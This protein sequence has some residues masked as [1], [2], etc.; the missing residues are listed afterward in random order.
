[1]R[2][3]HG[4]DH[5]QHAHDQ[6]AA[7]HGRDGEG[8]PGI[9]EDPRQR[10][11]RNRR[12][13]RRGALHPAAQLARVRAQE[14]AEDHHDDGE[15]DRADGV[16]SRQWIETGAGGR[17]S[18]RRDGHRPEHRAHG[19]PH[20]DPRDRASAVRGDVD[21]GGHES[22]ELDR[23]LG[24]AHEEDPEQEPPEIVA[25]H[26]VAGER[27]A[28]GADPHPEHQ[29]RPA[30]DPVEG[31]SPHDRGRGGPDLVGR[32][33]DAR[34]VVPAAEARAHDRVD[35]GRGEKGGRPEPGGRE[36]GPRDAPGARGVRVSGQR[37]AAR[38]TSSS[39]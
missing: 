6:L 21:L 19:G 3:V 20:H 10:A 4:R 39:V 30:A 23:G 11:R 13:R 5:H 27:R 29:R 12:A 31:D 16:G 7:D 9:A 8:G 26:R 1:M 25:G 28:D 14:H 22:S 15:Q 33:R 37:R 36:E 2:H 34:P 35:G 24:H 17:R 38:R 18:R 32:G